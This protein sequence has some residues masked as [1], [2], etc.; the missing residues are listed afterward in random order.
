MQQK[1]NTPTNTW[2]EVKGTESKTSVV[3]IDLLAILTPLKKTVF[4]G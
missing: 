1:H 4:L 2:Y 3:L